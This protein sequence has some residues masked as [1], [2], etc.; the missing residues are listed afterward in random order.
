MILIL[1]DCRSRCPTLHEKSE[2]RTPN[3]PPPH[4]NGLV[5][6]R[7]DTRTHESSDSG[8]RNI[9]PAPG[10][11]E[12]KG[13]QWSDKEA[14]ADN[15]EDEPNG[16]NNQKNM[17][18]LRSAKKRSLATAQEKSHWKR[19]IKRRRFSSPLS[20][21]EETE[22]QDESDISSY[23]PTKPH[24]ASTPRPTSSH[25]II[26]KGDARDSTMEL[27]GKQSNRRPT[28]RMAV[29]Y[30]QQR[31]EGEIIDERHVKQKRGRP[32]KQYLIQWKQSWVDGGRLTAPDLLQ[33]WKEKGA[34]KCRR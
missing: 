14:E 32:H 21:D 4:C 27:V 34:L 23:A 19:R 18:L 29:I 16:G 2:H 7:H 25:L 6:L 28:S 11:G 30:E 17:L 5:S 8:R 26:L 24:D 12:D 20:S 1:I 3:T 15:Q 31:W 22:T 9:E 13:D 10:A 33:N